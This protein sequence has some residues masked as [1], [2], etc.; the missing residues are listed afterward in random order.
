M[1]SF[2]LSTESEVVTFSDDVLE[3]FSRQRQSSN[4]HE[5][6]GQLFAHLAKGRVD[7]LRATG[8]DSSSRRGRF[9]FIPSRWHEQREIR[10]MHRDGLHYVGDWHTHPEARPT[11][12]AKDIGTIADVYLKSKREVGGFLLVVVGLDSFPDGMFVGLSDGYQ[13]HRLQPLGI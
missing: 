3:H 10:Q 5:A 9:W 4:R 1:L 11:P 6:G 2:V 7:V 12:S 8:P 13:L